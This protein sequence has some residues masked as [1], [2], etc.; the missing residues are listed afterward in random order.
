[1]QVDVRQNYPFLGKTSDMQVVPKSHEVEYDQTVVTFLEN[2]CSNELSRL[3][4]ENN[5]EID[6]VTDEQKIVL[7]LDKEI[8]LDESGWE[9]VCNDILVFLA[10]FESKSVF[11]AVEALAVFKEHAPKLISQFES[12]ELEVDEISP[13]NQVKI[14]GHR[15]KV[16]ILAQQLEDLVTDIVEE[17]KFKASLVTDELKD[18]SFP[19][20]LLVI[21]SGLVEKLKGDLKGLE[22]DISLTKQVISFR[23]PQEMINKATLQ[24]YQLL[25]KCKE[26]TVELSALIISV[27]KTDEAEEFIHKSFEKKNLVAAV[28]FEND[29]ASEF[30]VIAVNRTHAQKAASILKTLTAERSVHLEEDQVQLMRSEKWLTFSES[31]KN[32][33]LK[34]ITFEQTTST[35]WFAG[36]LD[37][38][39]DTYNKVI[40]FLDEN[41]I[42]SEQIFLPTGKRKFLFK[43]LKDEVLAIQK[44][45]ESQ[46]VIIKQ[47]EDEESAVV[48]SG[49]EAGVEQGLGLLTVT[50]QSIVSK[51]IPIDMPGMRKYFLSD[52]G[53]SALKHIENENRCIIQ[54]QSASLKDK[55]AL[56]SAPDTSSSEKLVCSYVTPENKKIWLYKGDITKHRV[57]VV[58]NAAN[59]ALEHVGGVAKAIVDAGGKEIQDDCRKHVAQKGNLLDGEVFVT[60]AYKLPCNKII[61]AVGPR[62]NYAS[63]MSSDREK[64]KK[65]KYLSLAIYNSLEEG[66]SF[67]SIAF[68]AISTGVF[69]FPRDLCAKVMINTMLEYSEQNQ[70]SILKDIHIIDRDDTT[71]KTFAHEMRERFGK[72]AGFQENATDKK[73]EASPRSKKRSKAVGSAPVPPSDPFT[74]VTPKSVLITLRV[75]DLS[76]QKVST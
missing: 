30:T 51:N 52:Q 1:M 20:L 3:L 13:E 22:I 58:V 14:V 66:K 64:R 67:K 25:A 43:N 49:T 71:I 28:F 24:I 37:Y 57:D 40:K 45:L 27:L 15:E 46:S 62:W 6:K 65:E 76:Q 16:A 4:Q 21:R 23:G 35:L 68:P 26:E 56:P 32:N 7:R 38:V 31:F 72:E 47:T 74:I 61:H 12:N 10:Q 36:C 34:K 63:G 42:V 73:I 9:R 29:K 39:E 59:T 2:H 18:I 17:E 41:T 50:I 5:V 60:D 55:V 11:V 48:I 33:N 19:K 70:R 44:R 54:I 69:G 8:Q 75:G 53:D